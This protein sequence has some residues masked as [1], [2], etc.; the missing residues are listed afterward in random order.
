[1]SGF[2]F[3]ERQI[4]WLRITLFLLL[5]ASCFFVIEAAWLDL[6]TPGSSLARSYQ[7]YA[8]IDLVLMILIAVPLWSVK[9]KKIKEWNESVKAID[10]PV[11]KNKIWWMNLKPILHQVLFIVIVVI[12]AYWLINSCF[13]V[14]QE[15]ISNYTNYYSK[16]KL[17]GT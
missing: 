7:L 11:L 16:P 10:D 2:E 4:K 6:Y 8:E 17:W 13:H 1:M 9:I 12:I 5:I 3:S 15:V 14:P